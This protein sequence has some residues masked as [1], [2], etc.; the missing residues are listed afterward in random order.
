[1]KFIDTILNLIYPPKCPFCNCILERG[2]EGLCS[3]CQRNLPW[4]SG[5]NDPVDFCDV[6]LSPLR[7]QD[8]VRNA[9]H[10]YKFNYGRMHSKFLGTLMAQCLSDRWKEPV[11]VIVWVPLSRK[12]RRKRGYDQAE[13]LAHRVSELTGIPVLDG[14]EKIRDTATQSRI[15]RPSERRANVLGAYRGKAGAELSGKRVVL[16]DDVVTSGATLSECASC[17]RMAGAAQVVALTFACA[18]KK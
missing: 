8:G 13:L 15:E 2:E 7:Y 3:R 12:H 10:R 1:M 16:V 5:H 6:S 17:L 18:N 4:T 9:V 11:D 14:L